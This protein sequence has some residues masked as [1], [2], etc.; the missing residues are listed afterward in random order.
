[1]PRREYKMATPERGRKDRTILEIV[2]DDAG[3][4][5]LIPFLSLPGGTPPEAL[6]DV[7]V[8]LRRAYQA[9]REDM[10]AESEPAENPLATGEQ[11]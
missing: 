4:Q 5:D 3:G 11:Q 10:A 6:Y 9:G 1:M 8:A 7:T 2:T